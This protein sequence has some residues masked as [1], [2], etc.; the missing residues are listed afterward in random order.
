MRRRMLL[1]GIVISLWGC[2]PV[3]LTPS[4]TPTPSATRT[5]TPTP[6]TTP[7]PTVTHSPTPQPVLCG[8]PPEMYI[9]VIGSD[10]RNGGYVVGLA[11]AIRLV[12]VDF[13]YPSVQVLAFHRDLYVE[14]PNL[15]T[16]TNITHGKLNQAYLYGNP[17]YAYYKGVDQ[18]PGLMARTL[19]RN[20]GTRTDHYLAMNLSVFADFVDEVGGLEIDLPETID[21][22]VKGSKNPD[23]YFQKGNLKLNG[24]RTMLLARMRPSGDISRTETQNLILQ[25]LATKLLRPSTLVR[26]PYLAKTL[27]ESVQTDLDTDEI[28]QLVCLARRL[29]GQPIEFREFP[30]TLFKNDRVRDPVLGNTSILAADFT[31]LRQYVQRFM[32]DRWDELNEPLPDDAGR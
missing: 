15:Q 14:I 9:L 30:A 26:M 7:T 28:R 23:V 12:R 18:G 16:K 6:L 20:F 8:G 32:D 5:L 27:Q 25:A 29:N 21:G 22:R 4:I 3:A 17:G 10:A 24:Y 31:V 13:R 19:A 2:Q 1:L 11:D